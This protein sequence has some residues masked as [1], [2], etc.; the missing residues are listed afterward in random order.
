MGSPRLHAPYV[1]LLIGR[2]CCILS[3]GRVTRDPEDVDAIM[4]ICMI[5][6]EHYCEEFKGAIGTRGAAL[7]QHC[8]KPEP[9]SAQGFCRKLIGE[10]ARG[11]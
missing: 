6:L 7:V 9:S 4:I 8:G 11:T 3:I 1:L 5:K 10:S 2:M